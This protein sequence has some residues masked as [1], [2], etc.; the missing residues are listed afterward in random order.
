MCANCGTYRGRVVIDVMAKTL[1]KAE[2]HKRK[3]K[4]LGEDSKKDNQKHEH[5]KGGEAK[6]TEKKSRGL[7]PFKRTLQKTAAAS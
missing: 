5:T 2:R 4:E 3:Q 1:K 7:N 6:V